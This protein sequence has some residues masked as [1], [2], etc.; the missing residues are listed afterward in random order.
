MQRVSAASNVVKVLVKIGTYAFLAVMALIVLFPFYWM[1]ISSL[2]S[3]PEYRQA[4]PTFWPNQI[5]WS[6]YSEAFTTANLGDLFLNTA[7]VGIASQVS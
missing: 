4:I 3:L 5:I 6:N 2:K 1:I 7:Y